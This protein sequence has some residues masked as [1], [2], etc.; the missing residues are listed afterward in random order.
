MRNLNTL[1]KYRHTEGEKQFYGISGNHENGMFIIPHPFKQA[2]AQPLCVIASIGMGW[3]HV[4]VSLPTRC[5][6]WEE[7]DFI[8][9]MF[10]KPN[11]VVMQL[12]VADS[13]HIN[14][15]PNCLHMWRPVEGEIPLPPDFTVGVR[16][17]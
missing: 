2:N 7:M 14:N 5:P 11:E 12:H 13:S 10:F 1:N 4:S 9:R 3:E 6:T 15:H 8:K 16:D 17:H